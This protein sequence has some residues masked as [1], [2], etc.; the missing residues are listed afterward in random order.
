MKIRIFNDLLSVFTRISPSNGLIKKEKSVKTNTFV[1]FLGVNRMTKKLHFIVM[2]HF[3][4]I[5]Y[6]ES[7]C[8]DIEEVVGVLGQCFTRLSTFIQGPYAVFA[9]VKHCFLT[10][11]RV[12]SR[13][14]SFV[15]C[16]ASACS[17]TTHS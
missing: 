7:S 9:S 1:G 13:S 5:F 16:F 14:S 4:C 11:L 10:S 6:S 3:C 8:Q 15:S 17:P 12:L 2:L